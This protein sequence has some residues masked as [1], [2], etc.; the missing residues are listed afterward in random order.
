MILL[1]DLAGAGDCRFSPHCWRVRM[2]LAHKGL[3]YQTRATRFTEIANICDGT[4][5]TVPVIEDNGKIVSDSWAIANYLEDTYPQSA[6][7]FG[8]SGGRA[9]T[10][11]V[12]NWTIGTVQGGIINLI[13]GDIH[14]NLDFADKEYFRA[15]REKRFGR[16]LEQ[17]QAGREERLPQFRESLQPLRVL[18]AAQPWIGGDVPLYA[19]YLVFGAFQWARMVSPFTLLAEDD[20]I[21]A[22]FSRALD[23]HGGLGRQSEP[24]PTPPVRG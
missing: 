18:L 22:W 1:Y 17:V 8:G 12:Q 24:H 19:D 3:S 11:F 7:L 20:P 9:L 6:S 10:K 14:A 5:K 2:A 15:S 4:Q 16:T 23:L 13:L 21:T